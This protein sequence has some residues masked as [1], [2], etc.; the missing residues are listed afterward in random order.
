MT[1]GCVVVFSIAAS[2]LVGC[3]AIG[4]MA[5]SYERSK[6]VE[7]SAVYRGL[8]NKTVA[9]LIDAPMEIQ[10]EHQRAVP[11]LTDFI[12]LRLATRCPGV[13][14]VPTRE[15]LAWQNRNVSWPM[16]DYEILAKTLGVERLVIV[17]LIEYRLFEPGNSYYWD[18]RAIGDVN[19]FEV[20]SLDSTYFAYSNRID[21]EFPNIDAVAR[22]QAQAQDVELGLQ[23]VFCENVGWLFHDHI[24]NNADL[25]D[26]QRRRERGH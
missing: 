7:I 25:I 2:N 5:A 24:R 20:E 19:V 10:F 1:I 3:Q 17:D 21:I 11:I 16:M 18:G 15:L 26:E 4:G 14:V 12:S 6:D 9:V 8:E 22:H 23:K 13:R